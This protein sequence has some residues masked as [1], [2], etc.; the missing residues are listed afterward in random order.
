M[1]ENT[2]K[3][4]EPEPDNS[5]HVSHERSD[6]DVFQI[7]V[8][9]VGLVVSCLISVVIV[10]GV[11][12]FL[13]KREDKVNPA[14]MPAMMQNRQMM[15]P[16]PRLSGV[17]EG[18]SKLPEPAHIELEQL[19][20]SET[21]LLNSYGWMDQAKGTAHIPIATAIDMMAQKGLLSKP[22]PAGAA[23]G[24]RMI[25]SDASSGRTLEKISQ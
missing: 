14:S 3:H 20:D 1:A 10:W 5:S 21:M 6:V 2:N 18:T 17:H 24:F 12:A 9:G 8:Y 19:R 23:G 25:P 15:P 22:S 13:A 7:A 11:F 4:H 16:E